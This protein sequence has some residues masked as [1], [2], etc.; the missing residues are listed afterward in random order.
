MNWP[1]SGVSRPEFER[2]RRQKL[3]EVKLERDA[4][5][6][7]ASERLRKVLFGAHP[8][9]QV[10]PSEEQ[11]A[12][13]NAK[14]CKSISDAYTPENGLLLLVEISIRSNDAECRKVFAHGPAK[15]Q[16]QKQLQ[17][18]RIR[19]PA[20]IPGATCLARCKHKSG[21]PRHHRKNPDWVKLGLTNSLY[22]GA[23]NS[24]L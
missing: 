15:N 3:E 4:T 8:Y 7:L 17:R 20:G 9:A 14:I 2:E 22:G 1:G 21:D 6:F 5:G 11:V 16:K 23:F 19:A 24:R 12:A 13:Y 18:Q 10:S